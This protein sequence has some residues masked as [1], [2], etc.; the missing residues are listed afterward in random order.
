MK[1]TLRRFHE[2]E[3]A[4][5]SVFGG[6][7][8]PAAGAVLLGIG[9]ANDTGWLAVAGGVIAAVGLLLYDGLRHTAIDK[10]IFGRLDRL[11][12]NKPID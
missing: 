11:D 3:A 5:W 1:D 6:V 7:I 2:D 8:V 10:P 4:H 12:G 9:A